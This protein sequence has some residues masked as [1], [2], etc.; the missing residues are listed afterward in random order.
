MKRIIQLFT[1][2][3]TVTSH[4]NSQTPT[5]QWLTVINSA[6][7]S[8]DLF[9][10]GNSKFPV[11]LNQVNNKIAVT[12]NNGSQPMASLLNSTTGAIIFSNT[13]AVTANAR[14]LVF[15][16]ND[17]LFTISDGSSSPIDLYLRK[18]DVTGNILL[19]NTINF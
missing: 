3:F 6:T 4:V 19:N 1:F 13:H 11:V 18:F 15:D 14:D 16:S 7:N 8:N 12:N 17:N 10:G 5:Q 9:Q 2:I